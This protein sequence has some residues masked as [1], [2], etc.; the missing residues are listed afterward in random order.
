MAG[1]GDE[2]AA[3]KE[4]ATRLG[5]GNVEFTGYLSGEPLENLI[6]GASCIT[7]TSLWYENLPLTILGSFARGKPV[8]GS[9]C[10]GIGELVRDGETGY[11]FE[12]AN[13]ASLAEA[14]GKLQSDENARLRM[15]RRARDLVSEEHSTEGHYDRLMEMYERVLN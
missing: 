6:R 11:L 7:V 3:F 8:V 14:I 12:R 5:L 9:D 4:R 13:A 2:L 10:G 15:A 1:E